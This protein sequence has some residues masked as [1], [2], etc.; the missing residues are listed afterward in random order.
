MQ[1]NRVWLLILAIMYSGSQCHGKGVQTK[2]EQD[3]QSC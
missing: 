3:L 2:R 1:I